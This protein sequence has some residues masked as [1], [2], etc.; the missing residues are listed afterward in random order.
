MSNNN[1]TLGIKWTHSYDIYLLTDGNGNVATHFGD[2]SSYWFTKQMNGAFVAPNGIYD[3]LVKNGNNVTTIT[4]PSS[5]VLTIGYTSG[6]ITSITD[7]LSRVWN[8]E[9]DFNGK[10]RSKSNSLG[11]STFGASGATGLLRVA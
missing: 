1:L 10:L 5:R 8:I 11:V 2:D 7:P 6:K 3:T 9:Y 4:D